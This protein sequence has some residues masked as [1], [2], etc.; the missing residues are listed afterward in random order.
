MNAERINNFAF[1]LMIVTAFM[2]YSAAKD[3]PIQT[4][5][6]LVALLFSFICYGLTTWAARKKKQK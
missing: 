1:G 3:R 2:V 4:S 6:L 5:K